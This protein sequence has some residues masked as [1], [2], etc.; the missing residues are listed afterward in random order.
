MRMFRWN[1]NDGSLMERA[2]PE[3]H[4]RPAMKSATLEKQHVAAMQEDLKEY[5]AA[6]AAIGFA[7]PNLQIEAFKQFLVKHDLPV[8]SLAEVVAYMDRKA[9]AEAK[10]K[11]GWHWCPLRGKDDRFGLSFGLGG[12]DIRHWEGEANVRPASDFYR[13]PIHVAAGI[14]RSSS[15]YTHEVAAHD[16]AASA[17]P[18]Q[19][20]VPLHALKKVALIES[21]FKD[22][23]IAFFVC[24]YAPAPAPTIVYPDP[25]LMAV[26]PNPLANKGVGRFIL[27][28]W[29]EPNFGISQMVK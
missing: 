27:D 13:G 8:F 5:A 15:G 6:A 19:W 29:D 28:F 11:A 25:F 21:E 22:D 4:P 10:D 16:T 2:I 12:S 9:A 1:A 3:A 20:T 23:D 26:I 17:K 14:V 7:P 18:Y 24:D